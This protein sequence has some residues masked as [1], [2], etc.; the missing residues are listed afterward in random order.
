MKFNALAVLAIT[1]CGTSA[2]SPIS[3]LHIRKT[4]TRN[5]PLNAIDDGIDNK[6]D[7]LQEATRSAEAKRL[8]YEKQLAEV[9]KELAQAQAKSATTAAVGGSGL[10]GLSSA[11]PYVSAPVVALVVGRTVLQKRREKIEEEDRVKEAVRIIAEQQ[12]I[13][14]Q[15]EARSEAEDNTNVS[16]INI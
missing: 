7:K 2:F 3:V 1:S 5:K 15:Q 12:A 8:Q 6:L 10:A 14:S 4:Q 16:Y 11:V 9:E 13:L